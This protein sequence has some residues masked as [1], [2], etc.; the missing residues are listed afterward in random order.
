MHTLHHLV[1]S[2]LLAARSFLN[3]GTSRT[4]TARPTS[5]HLFHETPRFI[6]GRPYYISTNPRQKTSCLARHL[7]L[8]SRPFHRLLRSGRRDSVYPAPCARRGIRFRHGSMVLQPEFSGELLALSLRLLY[9]CQAAP[10][11][12]VVI[13]RIHHPTSCPLA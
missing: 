9:A 13:S 11:R 10:F 2:V 8:F 1:C 4:R 6:V 5:R 7:V 12:R 3:Q